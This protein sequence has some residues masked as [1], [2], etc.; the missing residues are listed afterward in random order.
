VGVL[1]T[2]GPEMAGA[3][4]RLYLAEDE[5]RGLPLDAAFD[6]LAYAEEMMNM[7][8]IRFSAGQATRKELEEAEN[9]LAAA[10]AAFGSATGPNGQ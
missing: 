6:R 5:F 3:L 2:S 4:Y 8:E 1:S 7:V 9:E 10:K